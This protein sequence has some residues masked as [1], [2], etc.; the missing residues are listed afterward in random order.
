MRAGGL[1]HWEPAAVMVSLVVLAIATWQVHTGGGVV[2][3]DEWVDVRIGTSS[4]WWL[5]ALSDVGSPEVSGVALA[6]TSLHQAF[7]R[8][9]W[10]PLALAVGNGA[11]AAIV[12]LALKA[13]TGRRGPDGLPLDGYPGYF[14]SGHTVTAAVCLGTATYILAIA[15]RRTSLQ[16]SDL[17]LAVGLGSGL[18]VGTSAVLTGNHWVSDVVAGLALSVVLLL[19]GFAVLRLRLARRGQFSARARLPGGSG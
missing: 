6:V 3:L 4:A 14:P 2:R 1:C 11:A 7:F 13:L 19:V 16:A 8:G 10:W 5:T 12:V 15:R 18:V 9:R 17:A